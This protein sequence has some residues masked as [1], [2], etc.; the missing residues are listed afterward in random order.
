MENRKPSFA[1]AEMLIR[2]PV[3]DVF[4][5]R[6]TPAVPGA[7]PDPAAMDISA[8]LRELNLSDRVELFV[9]DPT[10]AKI[11]QAQGVARAEDA[12]GIAEG[13]DRSVIITELLKK[14]WDGLSAE[15]KQHFL[16]AA[17]EAV[18]ANRDRIRDPDLIYPG[19]V[20]TVPRGSSLLDA[21]EAA[22]LSP[23]HGCRMG[24]CNTCACG[25]PSGSTR[26]LHTG[27]LEH[28]PVTAL[29]LC[30]NRAASDLTLDL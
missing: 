23:A 24:I 1:T 10:G 14:L 26:H 3:A 27:M 5:A 2:K 28:E 13:D 20:L 25:K 18:K 21:L 29:R 7:A 12:I 16:D 11:G 22:G 15:V 9:F 8:I 17:K 30:V 6:L 4:E 19:Q